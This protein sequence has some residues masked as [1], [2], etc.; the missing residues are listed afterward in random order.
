MK[1]DPIAANL[2]LIRYPLKML[3]LDFNRNVTL[4]RL[5]SGRL[6]IHSTAPFSFVDI[7]AIKALGEVDWIVDTL[8]RHDTFAA[9]GR[10]AF[11]AASYLAPVDFSENLPFDTGFLIPAPPEWRDEV[12]VL[13]IEGAPSFGE[14][15]TFH[16]P[17]RTL[18]VADLV[19]HFPNPTGFGE[20]W[21]L[22][23]A[24]VGG[25]SAP[26]FTRPFHHAVEDQ[27]AFE[28]SLLQMLEWDFDRLI[29]GHG[30]PILHGAKA[31]LRSALRAAGFQD[32]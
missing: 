23:L 19:V 2:W 25:K 18:I 10:A 9:E 7:A 12:E 26:G 16:R 3:G 6:I 24:T 11:P 5:S 17:S 8:L 32:I 28:N 15:V 14:I 27:P 4:I 1:L 30:V 22:K 21:L 13:A 31:K 29:V 20:K